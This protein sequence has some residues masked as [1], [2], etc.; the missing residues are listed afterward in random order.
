MDERM[1][2]KK[3]IEHGLNLA[4]DIDANAFF[5]FTESGRSFY[6]LKEILKKVDEK[7]KSKLKILD[8][9]LN[10]K[11]KIIVFTPNET[12]YKKISSNANDDII[13]IYLSY[14]ENGRYQIVLSGLVY[15]L[16]LGYIKK[17]DKVVSIVGPKGSVLDTIMILDVKE[18]IK[19]TKLYEFLNNLEPNIRKTVKEVLKLALELGREGREGKKIGTI[20]VIGDTLNV[21]NLSRPLILNPFAGHNVKVF[22]ED[23]KGTIK[24]LSHIDG[25][26]IITEEG[27]VVAAGRFLDI[28]GKVEIK[29]G[30]GARH[31][32]AASI[33][34]NTNAIA[35]TISESG[36]I[37]RVFKDGKIIAEIQ[38]NELLLFD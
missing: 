26:F 16:N 12:T 28:G 35:I 1:W 33:T 15:S 36:G 37:V 29:K 3:L 31:L 9:I 22:D 6:I 20:F 30:L 10:K 4:Y 38:P 11:M 21:M 13:V 8:K 14:R 25:A 5:L 27:K 19:I 32:A 18:H 24:E 2:V 23:V 7:K 34:K 17:E